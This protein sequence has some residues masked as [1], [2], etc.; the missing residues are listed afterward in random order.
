M[1]DS[2]VYANP[3]M[4]AFKLPQN[5]VSSTLFECYNGG[6]KVSTYTSG[7]IAEKSGTMWDS[8]FKATS[9]DKVDN[10]LFNVEV[11]SG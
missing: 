2:L 3:K 4:S 10:L 6:K 5:D 1:K 11:G 8:Y 7:D 9:C